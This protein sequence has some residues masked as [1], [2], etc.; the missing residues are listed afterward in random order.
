M[1]ARFVL[2]LPLL[3]VVIPAAPIRVSALAQSGPR[4]LPDFDT[5]VKAT[6]D[7]LIRS[8][9]EQFNYAYKERRSEFH[10]NPFGR[11]GTGGIEGYEVTP[12][13]NGTVILKKLIERDGKPVT[14]GDVDRIKVKEERR[15]TGRRTV[16]EDVVAMLTFKMARREPVNGRDSIVFTFTPKPEG[17][18]HTR[19]GRIA[20]S[21]SGS[22][23]VDEIAHE[24][25][26]IEA[27]AVDAISF[28]FG[29]IAR[30]NEGSTVMLHRQPIEDGIWLP[31]SIRFAGEGR[32]LL[33]RKLNV[34]QRIEWSDY[35][36]VLNSGP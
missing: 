35:R 19:E 12:T 7:N 28:G 17:D 13:E 10:V 33:L 4:P 15:R 18:P 2:L 29:L 11:M 1:L 20:K 26:R 5:F 32:A 3:F 21:F 14:D 27:T 8:Q 23:W 34:D 9:R 36:K 30:L 25:V 24:V 22:V 31:T 16:M 6:R